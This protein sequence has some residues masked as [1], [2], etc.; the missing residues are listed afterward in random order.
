MMR[1]HVMNG[2]KILDEWKIWVIVPILRGTVDVMS[3]G[4]YRTVTLPEHAMKTDEWVLE[5]QTLISLNRLQSGFARKKS[6][7]CY[8]YCQEDKGV[9][10]IK[11][12]SRC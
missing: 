6:S 5:R 11:R 1:Q 12:K 10:S 3:C 2:R 8:I 4:S 7:G 9:M